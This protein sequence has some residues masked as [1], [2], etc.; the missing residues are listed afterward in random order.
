MCYHVTKKGA[1]DW[2]NKLKSNLIVLIESGYCVN[3]VYECSSPD[4][5]SVKVGN[6]SQVA[7]QVL[8]VVKESLPQAPLETLCKASVLPAPPVPTDR[9]LMAVLTAK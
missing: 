3:Y 9:G 2:L 6:L 4:E 8:V 7:G 1:K 5:I